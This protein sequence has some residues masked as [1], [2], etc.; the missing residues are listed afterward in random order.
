MYFPRRLPTFPLRVNKGGGT[1][2][3]G[4]KAHGGGRGRASRGG[5][6]E[7]ARPRVLGAGVLRDGRAAVQPAGLRRRRS[8]RPR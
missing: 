5:G 6:V 2:A 4:S 7:H 1:G 3:G 8:R